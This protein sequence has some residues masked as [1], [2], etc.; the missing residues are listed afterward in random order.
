MAFTIEKE[1]PVNQITED[2]ISIGTKILKARLIY[3]I[4]KI[5]LKGTNGIAF[6]VITSDSDSKGS[7]NYIPFIYSG[8]G[9]PITEAEKA[10]QNA[11]QQDI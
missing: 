6:Y 5:E 9:D 8:T 11:I 3:S 10:L 7:R 4:E 1:L 2:G